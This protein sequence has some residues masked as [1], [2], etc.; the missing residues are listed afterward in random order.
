VRSLLTHITALAI[1][2]KVP[3][4]NENQKAVGQKSVSG[5]V[6]LEVCIVILARILAIIYWR[7]NDAG[8]WTPP[9]YWRRWAIAE[10]V[11]KYVHLQTSS[12]M[13]KRRQ[14]SPDIHQRVIN[15]WRAKKSQRKIAQ[16][17]EM[18][19]SSVQSILRYYR[20]N[21]HTIV[22][23]RSGRPRAT[24]ARHDRAIV[25]TVEANRF[26]SSGQLAAQISKKI[27][28][29]VSQQLVCNHL[30]DTGLNGRFARKKPYLSKLH[31]R[32]RLAYAKKYEHM[33]AEDWSKTMF[34][35]EASVELNGSTGR[36]YVWRPRSLQQQVRPTNEQVWTQ[37][38]HGVCHH[39]GGWCG[40]LAFLHE[41][42]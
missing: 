6:I 24:T 10:L 34:A 1:I 28:K 23:P 13:A 42:D 25:R 7:V 17:L 19:R 41:V 29:E 33:D 2:I 39:L 15:K 11:C 16:E 18:P 4:I 21:G 27:G 26:L 32:K 31:R 38:F 14:Y 30:N 3:P 9:W 8:T 37:E 12:A 20:I 5:C 40:A 22:A 35:D 36:V